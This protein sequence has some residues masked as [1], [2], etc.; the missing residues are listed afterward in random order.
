MKRLWIRLP[1][2]RCNPV[3]EVRPVPWP[4]WLRATRVSN[5]KFFTPLEKVKARGKLYEH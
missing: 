5:V 1:L 3:P 4:K 2:I